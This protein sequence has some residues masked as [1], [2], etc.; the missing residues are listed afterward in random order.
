M[1]QSLEDLRMMVGI[2]VRKG[3]LT[4]RQKTLLRYSAQDIPM[5]KRK[6]LLRLLLRLD[7]ENKTGD[8][9]KWVADQPRK[10]IYRQRAIAKKRKR[11]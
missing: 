4:K 9:Q 2:V 6:S 1:S 7:V 10:D 3:R 8:T 5:A 11:L